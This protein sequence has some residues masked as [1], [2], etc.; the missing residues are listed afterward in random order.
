MPAMT[1]AISASPPMTPPTIAPTGVEWGIG[2]G[3]GVGVCVGVGVGVN[4]NGLVE[5]EVVSIMGG[6]VLD[7]DSTRTGVNSP[8]ICPT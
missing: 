5:T 7:A 1:A 8:P 6:T 2:V 4:T 3:V